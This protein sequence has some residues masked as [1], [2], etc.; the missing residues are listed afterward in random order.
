MS[1]T[2]SNPE[3]GG[4][5]LSNVLHILKRYIKSEEIFAMESTCEELYQLISRDIPADKQRSTSQSIQLQ[6]RVAEDASSQDQTSQ[7][8]ANKGYAS[9]S[10]HILSEAILCM[11]LE[12]PYND[13]AQ[14]KLLNLTQELSK[15]DILH[16]RHARST[17]VSGNSVR[18]PR[19]YRD[20]GY[21]RY[22]AM[23][24]LHQESR[25]YVNGIFH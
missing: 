22:L 10:D 2:S 6:D 7:I 12:I 25:R 21:F 13:Q 15:C 8:Q 1:E 20:Y 18:G 9:K 4:Y 17:M 19:I 5:K 24:Y 3:S 23:P 16:K 14:T 11:S